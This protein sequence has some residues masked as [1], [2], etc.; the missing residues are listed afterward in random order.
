MNE[1]HS[2]E[3]LR[4]PTMPTMR[5]GDDFR[6]R[7]SICET[8]TLSGTHVTERTG[9]TIETSTICWLSIIGLPSF[10]KEPP[11]IEPRRAPPALDW[12]ERMQRGESNV[13]CAWSMRAARLRCKVLHATFGT[14]VCFGPCLGTSCASRPHAASSKFVVP[15]FG[16]ASSAIARPLRGRLLDRR[17]NLEVHR[18]RSVPL[19]LS[20]LAGSAE[21]SRG[22]VLVSP[23]VGGPRGDEVPGRVWPDATT[24]ALYCANTRAH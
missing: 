17:P 13:G 9:A 18:L 15:N 11:L 8:C 20:L 10:K 6:R 3:P 24:T 19:R 2:S 1:V 22:V 4:F 14:G 12:Q 23:C 21:G 5:V 7:L 16:I